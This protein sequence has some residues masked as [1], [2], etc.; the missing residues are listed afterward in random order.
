[1]GACLKA[2]AFGLCLF[3]GGQF[4]KE[5]ARTSSGCCTRLVYVYISFRSTE[6]DAP[7]MSWRDNE[8]LLVSKRWP[9]LV[10]YMHMCKSNITIIGI[11]SHA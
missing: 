1:M 7:V 9:E 6:F 5:G 3:G 10:I 4:Y 2:T 8:Q 11:E